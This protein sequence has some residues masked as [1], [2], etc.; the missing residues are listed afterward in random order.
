MA[1]GFPPVAEGSEGK[2]LTL[3][4]F[5]ELFLTKHSRGHSAWRHVTPSHSL[6]SS[7]YS[8]SSH[9]LHS[10]HSSHPSE[11]TSQSRCH[12]TVTS[13]PQNLVPERLNTHYPR[14]LPRVFFLFLSK[15]TFC[16]TLEKNKN[17]AVKLA[18]AYN[19]THI[20]Y[21]TPYFTSTRLGTKLGMVIYPTTFLIWTTSVNEFL[22]RRYICDMCDT[23]RRILYKR[24]RGLSWR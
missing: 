17:S 8:H 3:L 11:M 19:F 1:A 6:H 4:K 24:T 18:A 16:K 10:S 14:V 20:P 15:T 9:S 22:D 7:H 2:L 12:V 23:R 21:S 13:P 5:L